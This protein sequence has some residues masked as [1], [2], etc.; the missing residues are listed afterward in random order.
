MYYDNKNSS[1][2]DLLIVAIITTIMMLLL[3]SCGPKYSRWQTTVD[4]V[5]VSINENI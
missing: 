4:D 5:I 1:F 3:F 2:V